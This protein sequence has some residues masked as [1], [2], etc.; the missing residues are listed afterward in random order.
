MT[1]GSVH[2]SRRIRLV[3]AL[4]I[5]TFPDTGK[6]MSLAAPKGLRP[7]LCAMASGINESDAEGRRVSGEGMRIDLADNHAILSLRH[8]QKISVQSTHAAALS[9]TVR[10]SIFLS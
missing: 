6:G 7:G 5:E 3:C 8:P 1:E 9:R 2:L 10:N 4:Y